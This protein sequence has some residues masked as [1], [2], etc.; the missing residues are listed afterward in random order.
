M[1]VFPYFKMLE[2]IAFMRIIEKFSAN[3]RISIPPRP[4]PGYMAQHP[5]RGY[6]LSTSPPHVPALPPRRLEHP[7]RF[8]VIESIT[9]APFPP[10]HRT[11]SAGSVKG[12]FFLQRPTLAVFQFLSH[13]CPC[14]SCPCLYTVVSF[15]VT[16]PHQ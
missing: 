2:S 3:S 1:S 6:P 13:D 14:I 8:T 16:Y 11:L 9:A 12:P 15:P 5:A 10:P 4:A 7:F